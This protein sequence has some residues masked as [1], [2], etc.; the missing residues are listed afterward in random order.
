MGVTIKS[1]QN[2]KPA[3]PTWEGIMPLTE[4]DHIAV[5]SHEGFVH[6]YKKPSQAR[7]IILET[8]KNALSNVLVWY[9]PMAGRLQSIGKDRY[10]INCNA[11]GVMLIEAESNRT[12][13]DYGDFSSYF[14]VGITAGVVSDVVGELITCPLGQVCGKIR[15]QTNAMNKEYIWSIIQSCKANNSLSKYYAFF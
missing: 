4:I 8:F 2:V 3:S 14:G 11:S 12:I 15:K 9:Y 10:E 13:E 7:H 6:I 1:R 5:V